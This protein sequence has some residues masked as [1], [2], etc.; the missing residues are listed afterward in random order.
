MLNHR[1]AQRSLRKDRH[2]HYSASGMPNLSCC[3][4]SAFSKPYFRGWS[5]I[6]QVAFVAALTTRV[7][8]SF[9]SD[10]ICDSVVH[11]YF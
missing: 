2:I 10:L 5:R 8:H 4:S 6:P 7:K 3:N 11:I 9:A 1:Q